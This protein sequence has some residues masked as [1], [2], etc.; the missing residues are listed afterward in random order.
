MHTSLY[1]GGTYQNADLNTV[2]GR[3]SEAHAV[4][5]RYREGY[6]DMWRTDKYSA[7]DQPMPDT[8]AGVTNFLHLMD[9]LF[10]MFPDFRYENCANGGHFK[11]F[12]LQRRFTFITTNDDSGGAGLNYR[13]THWVSV[14]HL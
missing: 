6:M 10:A 8:F 1:M 9:G 7:P 4:A 12:A 13:K 11:G 3:D 5:E 2:A 14:I